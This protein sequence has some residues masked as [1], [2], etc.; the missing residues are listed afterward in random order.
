MPTDRNNFRN[1]PPCLRTNFPNP[2]PLVNPLYR[3]IAPAAALL[4]ALAAVTLA[5]AAPDRELKTTPL[6]RLETR[7]LVQML[8]HFHYNKGAVSATDYPQIVTGYMQELDPQRLFFTQADEQAFRRQYGPRLETD[9]AYLGN[10]DAAFD[11]YKVYEQRVKARLSWIFE[12]LPGEFDFTTEETYAPDRTKS[13][14]PADQ[15]EADDLWSK[16]LKFEMLHDVLA[17]KTVDEAKETLRK[18]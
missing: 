15:A 12:K 17:K 10:I 1:N 4:V 14:F 18:R 9:L 16:R 7:T 13:P 2:T 3:R 11:I 5:P 8:E 6:M